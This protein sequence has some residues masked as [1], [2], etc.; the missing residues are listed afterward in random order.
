M[1]PKQLEKIREKRCL[2]DIPGPDDRAEPVMTVGEQIAESLMYHEGLS[3]KDALHKAMDML[4]L[5]GI[6]AVQ[7]GLSTRHSF[8]EE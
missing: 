4:E 8:P 1:T 6:P 5:V 2:H 3:R 7:A